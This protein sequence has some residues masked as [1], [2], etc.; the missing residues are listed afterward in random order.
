MGTNNAMG[1]LAV[2]S[3]FL[4]PVFICCILPVCVVLIVYIYRNKALRCLLVSEGCDHSLIHKAM[5]RL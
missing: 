3:D 5:E 4:L 1:I 2:I